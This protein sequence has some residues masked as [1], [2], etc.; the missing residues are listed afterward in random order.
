MNRHPY[1]FHAHQK[2]AAEFRRWRDKQG[3]PPAADSPV[4]RAAVQPLPAPVLQLLVTDELTREAQQQ[5]EQILGKPR[6]RAPWEVRER[7]PGGWI[8]APYV[9]CE[10]LSRWVRQ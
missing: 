3:N 10:R 8:N 5:I 4:I 7:F 9:T 1:R 2:A 6:R